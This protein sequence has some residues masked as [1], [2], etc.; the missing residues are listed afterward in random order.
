MALRRFVRSRVTAYRASAELWEACLPDIEH[1]PSTQGTV[2]SAFVCAF[3]CACAGGE[4]VEWNWVAVHL[5][6][7]V[8]V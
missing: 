4:G 1:I 5:C 8:C 7:D 2:I 6:V 3:V